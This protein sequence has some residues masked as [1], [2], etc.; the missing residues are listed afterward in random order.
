MKRD[1]IIDADHILY[2]L[3]SPPSASW[4]GSLKGKSL[5]KP[6]SGIKSL[7]IAFLSV[8]RNYEELAQVEGVMQGYKIGKTLIVISDK[9]NFRYDIFPDYKANRKGKEHTEEF[10]KLRK[11]ARKKF[12]PKQ[13]I[14][15]DDMVAYYVRKGGVGF[16]QDKDLTKGVAGIWFDSY[17]SR[18]HWVYTSEASATRFNYLQYVAGDLGDGIRGI[19][20]IGFVKAEALLDTHGW[21][22]KGVL[23]IYLAKGCNN[24]DAIMTRRLTSMSQWHPKKGLKL[25]NGEEK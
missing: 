21:S 16:T 15:A 14:E 3:A 12:A 4:K 13:N 7:K 5:V 23:S 9:S 17:H 2:A 18:K 25:F 8:V 24:Y 22:W 1:V 20:G 10:L 19:E 11:W 6:T